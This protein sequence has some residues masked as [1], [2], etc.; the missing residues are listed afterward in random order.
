MV[1]GEGVD[2]RARHGRIAAWRRKLGGGTPGGVMAILLGSGIG[3]L[4]VLAVSPILTRLYTPEQFGVLTVFVSVTSVLGTFVLFRFDAAIPLPASD[5]VAAAVAWLGLGLA[6]C[7]SVLT[8]LLGVWVA[9]PLARLVGTPALAGVWWLVAGATFMVAVDQVLLTWM[10]RE[11]RYRALGLR[12]GLQGAGQA[13][14][15]VGLGWTGWNP[16]GLLVGWIA[17]RIAAVGGLFSSG[18]LLRQGIPTRDG[19]VQ[20]AVRYRRFPLVSSWSALINALGQQAPFLVISA[21]YGSVTIG[22]LG[23]T[24]RV[25][26]APASMVGQAVGRVFQGEASEAVRLGDRPL[27]PIVTANTRI[28]LAIGA[29]VCVILAA[30]GPWLFHVVFGAAWEEAGQYARLLSVGYLAQLAVSPISLTLLILERQGTQLAWD[31]LRLV[32]TVGGPLAAALLGGSAIVAVGVLSAMFVLC[33]GTLFLVCWQAASR[34][35]RSAVSAAGGG[36]ELRTK[37]P[38][39]L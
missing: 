12:N 30:F 18:G 22:L 8:G 28:L 6:T 31:A 39:G 35:D 1:A 3:Q 9:V 5:R 19:L 15:Q 26:A 34:H 2:A 25:I 21:Y 23:L 11:K 16:V 38:G 17:G 29:P 37:G 36:T 10:V 24:I 7:L 32:L 13:A 27:R 4:L 20:A 33:Y 14:G